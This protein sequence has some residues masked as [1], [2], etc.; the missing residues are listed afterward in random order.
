MN[1]RGCEPTPSA[2][3]GP[4]YRRNAP[5][6]SRITRSSEPGTPLIVSGRVLGSPRCSPLPEGV[7]DVWQTNRR[8]LYS[9][10]LGFGE[11][12]LRGRLR[13]SQDGTYR[14]ETIVPGRYP[15]GPFARPRHIHFMISAPGWKDLT[16]QIFFEGDPDL[17][18]DPY[19]KTPLVTPL[20]VGSDGIST[21]RFDFVLV[22]LI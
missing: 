3:R 11:F 14:L 4:F 2:P 15:L 17:Q 6:R 13:T 19:V 1:E 12:F 9:R 10:I 22:P 16:T 21:V 7:L 18:T 20:L 8:G 5:F